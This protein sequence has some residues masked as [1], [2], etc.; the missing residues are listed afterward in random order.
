MDVAVYKVK[1]LA[2]QGELILTVDSS[3]YEEFMVWGKQV[4]TSND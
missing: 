1:D 2:V 4:K 3:R